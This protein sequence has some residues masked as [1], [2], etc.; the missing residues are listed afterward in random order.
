[1][2]RFF[3]RANLWVSLG[4]FVSLA[5]GC[6]SRRITDT[7]RTASEQ[8]LVSASVDKAVAQLDFDPLTGRKVFVDTSMVDRVDKSFV[9]ATV[10]SYAW[11]AGVA[12]VDKAEDAE[13]IME[14][15]CGAVGL[16]RNDFILGIPASD[17]PNPV[18]ASV[19]VPE[20]AAFKNTKQTGATRISFVTYKR[21]NRE[22]VY[23][24]GPT[25]GFSDQRSWWL[26][27]AGPF[28]S[29]NV[30]PEKTQENTAT[31]KE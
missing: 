5:A 29:D 3:M 11:R 31:V 18:G 23:A 12:L 28:K 30:M 24:S 22:F 17:I 7:P 2:I 6:G 19:P 9:A 1:M 25:Y 13:L 21:E 15:R 16:D 26:V 27:G 4:L 10:R 20:V 8:L 14:V